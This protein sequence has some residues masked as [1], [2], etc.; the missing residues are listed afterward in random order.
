M[1]A[2][3]SLLPSI[4]DIN[5]LFYL[6]SVLMKRVYPSLITVIVLTVTLPRITDAQCT[7]SG[8][9]PATPVDY[10]A[11]FGPTN[12]SSTSVSFPQFNPAIGTLACLKLKDSITGVSTTHVENT[13]SDSSVFEFLLTVSNDIKGP[14]GGGINIIQPYNTIYGPDTLA[15]WSVPGDTITYGPDT[16]FN[17]ATGSGSTTNTAPYLGLG[18]IDFTYTISGGVNSLEGGLNYNAGPTTIYWGEFHL[19]YYWCPA[20]ALA[21]TIQDFTAV[22]NGN[23]ILLQWLATNQEPNTVYEIQISTDGKNFAT[24]GEAESDASSTGTSSKYDYQYN[25]NP[26]TVG[27]LYFRVQ[28]TDG[29]GKISYTAIVV[30][31]PGNNNPNDISY[32]TY[33]NP[34]T[35][36]LLFQFNSN[37]T[38]RFL[39]QLVNTA[40]QVV[41][42]TAVTLTGTNQ[43]RMNLSPQPVKGLY[44]LRTSDLSHNR[45]FVSK[46]FID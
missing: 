25:F 41:Q 22:P 17:N 37:Q 15:P 4:F 6:K 20:A 8:G 46:V 26:A 10:Y 36:S 19:T 21:T 1:G 16:I 45:S 11:S 23:S 3:A 30:V 27:K 9:V 31:D 39:L 33:P 12:T 7:C 29:T 32:Q 44:F 14:A 24:L 13:G 2:L 42:E 43:I 34:A 18:N 5:P 28:E 40:G 38:G 35:N